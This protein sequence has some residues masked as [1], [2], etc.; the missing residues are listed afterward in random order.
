MALMSRFRI[1]PVTHIQPAMT[2][3]K[4][5]LAFYLRT[6]ESSNTVPNPAALLPLGPS[7]YL[8]LGE[9][10]WLDAVRE[11]Q[12]ELIP[13]IIITQKKR[14]SVEA[15]MVADNLDTTLLKEFAATFPKDV[16]L[17]GHSKKHFF[18]KNCMKANIFLPDGDSEM[19]SFRRI[20]AGRV[21]G[22]LFDFFTYLSHH[23]LVSERI[24]QSEISSANLKQNLHLTKI[25]IVD[26][27]VD[28]IL[29]VIRSGKLFPSGMLR[30]D[31]GPRVVGIN[32]PI[33]VLTEKAPI[34]DK[35]KFLFDLL[36]FRLNSGH[37]EFIRSGVYLLNY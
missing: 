1:V 33:R 12:I 15:G 14:V 21:P 32:Y 37:A 2:S 23:G 36:N 17:L 4:K 16:F 19:I 3:N 26:L 31:Y 29:S 7:R 28:E 13:A 11:A 5:A 30:F 6:L 24:Y 20:T 22:R 18:G 25:E 8:L 10:A 9:A 34:R 35:E 27:T